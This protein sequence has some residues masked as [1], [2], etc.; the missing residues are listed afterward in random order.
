MALSSGF[1]KAEFLQECKILAFWDC[2]VE[3]WE[4]GILILVDPF[5]LRMFHDPVILRYVLNGKRELHSTTLEM[6]C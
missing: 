1:C 5:Q 3:G 2:T 4:L 6:W